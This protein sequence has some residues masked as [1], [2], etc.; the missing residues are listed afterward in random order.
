MLS[1]INFPDR[2]D[3][4]RPSYRDKIIESAKSI[5]LDKVD[6]SNVDDFNPQSK[7]VEKQRVYFWIR[8]YLNDE[9]DIDPNTD[10]TIT[11]KP[12]GESLVSKFICYAKKGL[13]KDVEQNVVNYNPEDDKRILCLMVDSERINK[14]SDDIPFLRSLFR[15]SMWYQ[16]EIIRLSDFKISDSSNREFEFYDIDF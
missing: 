7:I 14:F 16:P 11:Y 10:V 15:I 2:K 9:V 12:E 5:D 6:Y 8:I 3:L 4:G 13:D 1:D